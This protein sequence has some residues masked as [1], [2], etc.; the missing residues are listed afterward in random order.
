MLEGERKQKEATRLYEKAAALQAR[1]AKER[2]EVELARVE[3]E[4]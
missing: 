2:L 1:D 3:L 4:A